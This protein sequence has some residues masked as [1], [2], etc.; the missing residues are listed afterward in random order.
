MKQ[1]DEVRLAGALAAI[2]QMYRQATVVLETPDGEAEDAA[3]ALVESSGAI[4]LED[5]IVT[6]SSAGEVLWTGSRTEFNEAIRRFTRF[7]D[8]LDRLRKALDN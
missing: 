4:E 7:T 8:D 6:I 5:G 1:F 2:D 3:E